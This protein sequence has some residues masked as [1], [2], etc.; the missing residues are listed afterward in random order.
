MEI[1]NNSTCGI[2]AAESVRSKLPVAL[3]LRNLCSKLPAALL[4]RNLCS[5]LPV[6][7]L[8]RNL[9]VPSCLWHCCCGIC[10]PSCLRHCCCGIC[11]PSCLWHCCCGICPFQATCGF[12]IKESDRAK[13]PATRALNLDIRIWY[14]VPAI[15]KKEKT[16]NRNGIL[17]ISG[18]C[19]PKSVKRFC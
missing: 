12:T 8:L 17:C 14:D 6:A 16:G 11:V 10:V 7:L 1:C 18:V 9:S 19:R 13:P 5:K 4:L 15:H 2:A 3:L